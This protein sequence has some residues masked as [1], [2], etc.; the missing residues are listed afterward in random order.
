MPQIEITLEIDSNSSLNINLADKTN[1]NIKKITVA[2]LNKKRFV[3]DKLKS[4]DLVK[5]T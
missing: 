3:N 4:I 5:K 2:G 1:G